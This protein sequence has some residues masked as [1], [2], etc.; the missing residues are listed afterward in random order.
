MI[1]ISKCQEASYLKEYCKFRFEFTL[2]GT[3]V[4]FDVISYFYNV[5][6][7]NQSKA[8]ANNYIKTFVVAHKPFSLPI[9]CEY[10]NQ[11]VANCYNVLNTSIDEKGKVVFEYAEFSDQQIQLPNIGIATVPFVVILR[12]YLDLLHELPQLQVQLHF[13][14]ES[15]KPT[16]YYPNYDIWGNFYC[17]L[18]NALIDTNTSFTEIIDGNTEIID[19]L[20]R[21]FEQF[22]YPMGYE[23]GYV[24]I[25]KEI[26]TSVMQDMFK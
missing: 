15:T 26:A 16:Y 13:E 11:I 14:F 17:P 2:L 20:Q 12:T 9:K 4:G 25:N 22:V 7:S 19:V 3:I 1:D 5:L 18:E 24:T 23:P 8:I 6:L 10:Q 21:Y